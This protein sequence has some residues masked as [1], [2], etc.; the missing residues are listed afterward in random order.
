MYIFINI[1]NEKCM[2]IMKN[3][4]ITVIML[5]N[6]ESEIILYSHPQR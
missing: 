4:S 3:A 1:S 6:L 2:H 5:K